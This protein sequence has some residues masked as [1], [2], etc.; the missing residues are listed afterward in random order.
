MA[1]ALLFTSCPIVIEHTRMAWNPSPVP[2]F[3]L[4]F[5]L[6]LLN[7]FQTH[8]N[9]W[10]N[11]AWV[12]IGLGIQ[13]H[14][15]FIFFAFPLAF[16]TLII[17]KD[18]WQWLKSVIL[19]L[20]IV[21]GLNFTLIVFDIRHQFL[22]SKAFINFLFGEK[23]GFNFGWMITNYWKVAKELID[24]LF[25]Q[26]VF[27]TAKAIIFIGVSLVLLILNR[28][29]RDKKGN[30]G[31]HIVV[32]IFYFSVLLLAFFKSTMQLY[33]YNFLFPLPFLIL[34]GLFHKF[35]NIGIVKLLAIVFVVAFFCFNLSRNIN[36]GKPFRTL[37][38][39]KEITKSIVDK[40]DK[41]KVFNI[42]AFSVE[43]WYTAEEYRY[44]TYYYNRRA[45][46]PDNYK[47]INT[48]FI[49]SDKPMENPL[50]IK[51]QETVEFSG[52]KVTSSWQIVKYWVYELVK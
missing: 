12:I 3:T 34:G 13:L 4:L 49:V 23:V 7:Y 2:F 43:P 20:F 44:F 18:F 17:M 48:L 26:G 25:F 31:N 5:V 47:N 39:I 6:F 35:R 38:Q 28:G 30:R 52:K 22:T 15:N 42:A 32:L 10:L 50:S 21:V 51:S 37:S 46:G 36:P 9:Y 1:I 41:D 40:T 11:L 19:G 8:K 14:Y 24:I 29:D 27:P 33:Y 16:T 45:K